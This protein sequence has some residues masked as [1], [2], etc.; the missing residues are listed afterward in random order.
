MMAEA[1]SLFCK[2]LQ[3]SFT[4]PFSYGLSSDVVRLSP[5]LEKPTATHKE[6]KKMRL[7]T[8]LELLATPLL[9]IGWAGLF[10]LV[11]PFYVLGEGWRS[12]RA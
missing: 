6:V 11:F 10:L 9:I 1:D 8:T 2:S 7:K 4:S 3:S 5:S 12:Y